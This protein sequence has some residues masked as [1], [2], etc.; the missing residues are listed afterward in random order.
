MPK[1]IIASLAVDKAELTL[2]E[3]TI[4]LDAS[5]S[6]FLNNNGERVPKQFVYVFTGPGKI[7]QTG[8]TATVT[9]LPEG[10]HIFTVD[11][12]N[13]NETAASTASV[14]VVVKHAIATIYGIH[15]NGDNITQKKVDAI[16]GLIAGNGWRPRF[17][18]ASF[19]P[20]KGI[21]NKKYITDQLDILR[22]NKLVAICMMYTGD[23]MPQWQFLRSAD[24]TAQDGVYAAVVTDRGVYP[25]YMDPDYEIYVK[26]GLTEL[27]KIFAEY[28]DVVLAF[29]PTFGSTG[30]IGDKG[31]YKGDPLDSQ[32]E[33]AREWWD[34]FTKKMWSWAH[35]TFDGALAMNPGNN[36][37]YMPWIAEHMPKVKYIKQGNFT[38]EI[39]FPGCADQLQRVKDYPG[40]IYFGET[41][42]GTFSQQLMTAITLQSAYAGLSIQ[43]VATDKAGYAGLKFGN[44]YLGSDAQFW[45]PHSATGAG[46]ITGPYARGI[47][48]SGGQ[49]GKNDGNGMFGLFNWSGTG[50]IRVEKPVKALRVWYKDGSGTL[51]IGSTV[52]R[53]LG[54]GKEISI[55]VPY[56]DTISSG[57]LVYFVE[58]V[59]A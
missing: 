12:E 9:D 7:T 59:S 3:N 50:M 44:T 36:G 42:G 5:G 58:E 21:F 23:N 24:K 48:I 11:V 14:S 43:N 8:A 29:M 17:D 2:P 41:E 56:S 22:A 39:D 35:D 15:G 28:K 13:K 34:A 57:L 54:T 30:D 20:S 6:Y 1:Q 16:A 26:Q 19:W 51:Q 55:D 10:N 49:Y 18:M 40:Y 52:V 46:L 47:S 45:F 33:I 32:Y 4:T 37:E 53:G 25:Y 38:H 31:G 27:F